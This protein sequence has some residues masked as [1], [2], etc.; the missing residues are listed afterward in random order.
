MTE[1]EKRRYIEYLA[2][3]DKLGKM[4]KDGVSLYLDGSE[5]DPSVIARQ[6]V[7]NEPES[8]MRDFNVRK[9]KEDK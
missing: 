4:K 9:D 5:E 7:F 3:V 1:S 8:Y 2:M 6:I